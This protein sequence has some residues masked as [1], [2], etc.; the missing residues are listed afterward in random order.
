MHLRRSDQRFATARSVLEHE[1]Q[2]FASQGR[3]PYCDRISQA[4]S[5]LR[6]AQALHDISIALQMRLSSVAFWVMPSATSSQLGR[7]SI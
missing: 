5:L 4:V 1:R 2:E 3:T 7:S 6:F